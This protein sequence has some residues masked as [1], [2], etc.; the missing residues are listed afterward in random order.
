LRLSATPGLRAEGHGRF[1]VRFG[2]QG[3]EPHGAARPCSE[4]S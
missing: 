4:P 3:K 1:S 2:Q